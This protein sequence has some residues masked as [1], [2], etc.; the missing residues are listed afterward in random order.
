MDVVQGGSVAQV[1]LDAAETIACGLAS[2]AAY[3]DF[4]HQP[5]VLPPG[6]REVARFTGWDA[7]PGGGVKERYGLVLEAT[8]SPGTY[9]VAFRGTAS[10]ADA[11]EDLWATTAAFVPYDA[12]APPDVWVASGFFGVY[13]GQGGDMAASM[14]AQVFAALDRASPAVQRV[15]VTGHSLGGSLASLFALDAALSRPAWQVTATTFASPRTGTGGFAALYNERLEVATFRVAS[16]WDYVPTMPPEVWGYEHVGQPFLVAFYV[17]D[18]WWP[19]L[20][21]RHSLLNYQHVVSRAV[22][23]PDQVWTGH[24]V[25]AA[26]A[27]LRMVSTAPPT[28]DVPEWGALQASVEVAQAWRSLPGG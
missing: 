24:F 23:Q 9:L 11:Y 16:F 3:A 6:Y 14:Q 21:A 22:V 7:T 15:V 27:R 25:D 28:V 26:D 2:L 10:V 4:D 20:T 5:V 19:Y 12:P 18:A 1:K 17:E 8:L 13:A